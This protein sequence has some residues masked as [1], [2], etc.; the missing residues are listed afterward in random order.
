MVH[1][2]LTGNRYSGKDR[3]AKLF[4]QIHIP[5][6][7]ADVVLRF[8]INYNIEL[9]KKLKLSMGEYYFDNVILNMD[10]VRCDNKFGEVIDFFK[11]DIFNAFDRFNKKNSKAIN[12]C[13]NKY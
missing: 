5:V 11:E 3:V 9:L 7:D 12:R 8:A 10:R 6:F 4:K 1:I 13:F 2:G